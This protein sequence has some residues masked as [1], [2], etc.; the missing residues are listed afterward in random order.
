MIRGLPDDVFLKD[1]LIIVI[2][3]SAKNAVLIVEFARHSYQEGKSL[4][5]AAM[6][7][8]IMRL[9]PIIMTSLAFGLGVVPLII[10]SGYAS[11][12]QHDSAPAFSEASSVLRFWL[13]FLCY[14]FLS[15]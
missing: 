12:I 10:A 4:R 7:A 8:A 2:G 11:E 15:R 5:E 13:L 3:L 14:C 1:S 6:T 9:R